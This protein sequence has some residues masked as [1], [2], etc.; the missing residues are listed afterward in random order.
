MPV[1]F[2]TWAEEM[3][4]IF[5]AGSSGGFLISGNVSD[6]VP[7]ESSETEVRFF[8]LKDYLTDVLF[9]QFEV[10]LTFDRGSGLKAVRGEEYFGKFLQVIDKHLGTQFSGVPAGSESLEKPGAFSRSPAAVIELMDRFLY[11]SMAAKRK[12]IA[13]APGSIA[14]ILDR[15]QFLF[16]NGDSLQISADTAAALLKV[17]GWLEDSVLA[18]SGS[19]ICLI[20]PQLGEINNL[21]VESPH[22]AKVPIPLPSPKE[23]EVYTRFLAQSE[24]KFSELSPLPSHELAQRLVGMSRIGARSVLWRALRNDQPLTDK[25]LAKLRKETIEKEASGRLEFLDSKRT[26][27]DVSG[28]DAAKAWLREDARLMKN[29]SSHALPMGYLLAGRIGTGKTYLVQ[30]FAGECGIPFVELKNFRDR[31]VGSTEANLEKVF[32]ILRALGRVVVFVDE[33]DQAT[34]KRDSGSGDSGL[35]GRVYAMLAKEM[36]ETRNRGKILWIFASSRPDL[37]EVDL[38]RQGRLDVHIPLFPPETQEGRKDLLAA[39]ARKVGMPLTLDQIPELEFPDGVGGNEFEGLL[40]RAARKFAL[41]APG[42]TKSIADILKDEALAF[43]PSAHLERLEFM[44]LLAVKEC[45][46]EAF[47]PSRYREMSQAHIE[48]RLK[49]LALRFG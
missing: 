38:K 31:W 13:D 23:M 33:A 1:V 35:S 41:Q 47:L 40:V 30:C 5:R 22:T 6:V 36:S 7:H 25:F 49:E 21:L 8:P 37:I 29:G 42:Q 17:L 2:P 18:Q 43:R 44:D 46:D 15:A 26:L 39:L 32:A 19:A 20:A 14:I 28:H 9:A 4:E 16:P 45:T 24:P 12:G 48:K 34:G 3:R 10:I 11:G 27:D